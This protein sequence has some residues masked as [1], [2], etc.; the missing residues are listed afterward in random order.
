M[1]GEYIERNIGD[2]GAIFVFP[3]QVA[4]TS[5]AR[6]A[7]KNT[8]FEC[9]ALERFLAWDDFVK[10]ATSYTTEGDLFNEEKTSEAITNVERKL[11]AMKLLEENAKKPFLSSIIE[12]QYKDFY[13]PFANYVAALLPSLDLY[14]KKRLKT[15]RGDEDKDLQEIFARYKDF[16]TAH[17]LHESSFKKPPFEVG[18]KKVFVF[19]PETLQNYYEYEAIL[20]NTPNL[21]CV[22]ADSNIDECV[23]NFSTSREEV[24]FV[25]DFVAAAIKKGVS[26]FEIAISTK[27]TDTYF[28][29]IERELEL[30]DIPFSE[31]NSVKL[32]R[33]RA[34]S[35]FSLIAE[36]QSTGWAKST[37]DALFS[38][39]VF[40]WKSEK[41]SNKGQSAPKGE[42]DFEEV[43]KVLAMIFKAKSFGA[44]H[45]AYIAFR[46]TFFEMAAF[47]L[48]EY[49]KTNLIMGQVIKTLEVLELEENKFPDLAVEN[50][51]NFFVQTLNQTPYTFQEAGGEQGV[52]L[53]S[54]KTSAAAFY[55]VQIVLDASLKSAG[56]EQKM[57]GFLSDNTRAALKLQDACDISSLILKMYADNSEE[58]LYTCAHKTFTG[59]CQASPSLKKVDESGKADPIIMGA[60]QTEG[61]EAFCKKVG[62][63]KAVEQS[64]GLG[65]FEKPVSQSVLNS[66]FDCLA[67]F[68]FH[69]VLGLDDRDYEEAGEELTID[70]AQVGSLYH[71]ALAQYFSGES[72]IERCV[73]KAIDATS[74][75]LLFT[76]DAKKLL[77][78][79]KGSVKSV[80]SK[81]IER[82]N[83]A[84][85]NYTV[86]EVE[87]AHSFD[88]CFI[89]VDLIIRDKSDGATILIDFKSTAA[90][91]EKEAVVTA[92]GEELP[93]TP[94]FQMPLYVYVYE[95]ETGKKID[96]AS[97][98]AIDPID[99]KVMEKPE[100]KVF[101]DRES[102]EG[103]IQ[104]ALGYVAKYKEVL[105]S[106][107]S[108]ESLME[109]SVFNWDACNKCTFKAI[110]RRTFNIARLKSGSEAFEELGEER[111]SE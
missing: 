12:V 97:Y 6:W 38:C 103:A 105:A 68:Y 3:T 22:H 107:K 58:V 16:L 50:P 18:D 62:E 41:K 92:D 2:E 30:R 8:S 37:L 69:F 47:K 106:G 57:L 94:D 36:V 93:A 101:T 79:V 27:D 76:K 1:I 28:P 17:T 39:E 9:V 20:A 54:Y 48:E 65:S 80:I 29:Y 66:F 35:L 14:D 111:D 99:V 25:A 13:A 67:K 31:K 70:N 90:P 59:Y 96:A 108:I 21:V 83:K 52:S 104:E 77:A 4:A 15:V 88:G 109:G 32:G 56:V 71:A 19:Y 72:D 46:N 85:P 43:K 40:P 82:F 23:K 11:F 95:G 61:F 110:C 86:I 7:V 100:K 102:Y 33:T 64:L 34:G 10:K 78:G 53:F 26:P 91:K 44:L 75:K 24:A 55:R 49:Q 98:F 63:K 84:Y 5:W 87:G 51:L 60:F 73:E 45:N 81:A 89:K 42:R 74:E